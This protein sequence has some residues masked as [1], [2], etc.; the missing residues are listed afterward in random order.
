MPC[1]SRN[2]PHDEFFQDSL[3][4][5]GIEKGL[6]IGNLTSRLAT[7]VFNHMHVNGQERVRDRD[8]YHWH[9]ETLLLN[10]FLAMR[11]RP[12]MG[13]GIPKDKAW[14]SKHPNLSYRRMWNIM[15]ALIEQGYVKQIR[16]GVH[17][18]DFKK[19]GVKKSKKNKYIKPRVGA[20]R[21]RGSLM[22]L[23]FEF[24]LNLYHVKTNLT[25]YNSV[26]AK[27]IKLSQSPK[28]KKYKKN[29]KRINEFYDQ[30]QI[31]LYIT[32][33]EETTIRR[34]ISHWHDRFEGIWKG[35]SAYKELNFRRKV[36]HRVFNDEEL[37]THGRFYGGFWLDLPKEW[38]QRLV[39]DGG[40]TAEID[41]S[42]NHANILYNLAGLTMSHDDFL[43]D[44]DAYNLSNL[45]PQWKD[46][47]YRD[48][49]KL[50]FQYLLNNQDIEGVVRSIQIRRST[51]PRVPEGYR[52]WKDFVNHIMDAHA[53]IKEY[54][55]KGNM[56]LMNID[57][58]IMEQVMLK[59]VDNN[60]CSL[61]IHDSLCVPY[62]KAP[63]VQ[64][65]MWEAMKE[66]TGHRGAPIKNPYANEPSF[67]EINPKLCSNY[68]NRLKEWIAYKVPDE[69]T[70][71][72]LVSNLS[73]KKQEDL[74]IDYF[75]PYHIRPPII[76]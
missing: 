35:D 55:F 10:F 65:W 74:E 60:I 57:S 69:V 63:Q 13:V 4:Y 39:I 23:F 9:L 61:S 18:K 20:Y 73:A 45:N 47:N 70:H 15:D 38:R 21:A 52:Y 42:Y 19:K 7:S 49:V 26:R 40:I 22:E 5:T 32:N 31:D 43:P 58:Q 28:L 46:N 2:L 48:D 11:I 1:M 64:T 27:E 59:C 12:E 72:N 76:K 6:G 25:D 14:Y 8:D 50:I 16:Q 66:F 17:N 71:W 3:I 29:L 44:Y 54:F 34:Q 51:H 37:E 41:F 36:A 62:G 75:S 56:K 68:F 30:T 33:E 67:L 53:P 24:N